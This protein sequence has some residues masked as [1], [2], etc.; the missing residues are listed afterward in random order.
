VEV[1]KV[2]TED[3]QAVT[4]LPDGSAFFEKSFP[5]P[6][7]IKTCHERNCIDEGCLEYRD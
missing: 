6:F 3:K 2:S 4:L 5:L 7:T 1:I